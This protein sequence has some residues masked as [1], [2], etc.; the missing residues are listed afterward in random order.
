LDDACFVTSVQNT[1][2]IGSVEL[3]NHCYKVSPDKLAH[4]WN[5]GLAT[6]K[7][8]LR[9]TMQ[10]GVKKMVNGALVQCAKPVTLQ[11]PFRHL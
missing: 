2:V 5:I 1:V 3:S 7:R 9:V 8:T 10:R 6:A 4:Y 11:L